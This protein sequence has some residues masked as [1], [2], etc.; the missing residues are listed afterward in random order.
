[1]L[2]Q[3]QGSNAAQPL[4][5]A[6]SQG[7]KN[8]VSIEDTWSHHTFSRLSTDQEYQKKGFLGVTAPESSPRYKYM[9]IGDLRNYLDYKLSPGNPDS[10]YGSKIQKMLGNAILCQDALQHS[11]PFVCLNMHDILSTPENKGIFKHWG[12]IS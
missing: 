4:L 5:N 11:G 10:L 12:S 1:M 7:K 3:Q 6:P 9:C 8:R 2:S